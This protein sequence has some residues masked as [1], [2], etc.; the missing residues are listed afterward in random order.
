MARFDTF[1]R[2]LVGAC[3]VIWLAVIGVSVAAT[4][5]LIDLGSGRA[6]DPA[7]SSQTPWVLYAIIGI[8]AAII[9]ASIPLLLRARR[10]AQAAPPEPPRRT[11]P[12]ARAR[13]EVPTEKLPVFGAVA[14]PVGRQRP[15]GPVRRFNP[16]GLRTEPLDRVL[17]RTA[18]SLAAAMGLAALAVMTAA[19]FLAVKD[20]GTAWLALSIAALI[21]V[22]MP[23][24]PWWQLRELRGRFAGF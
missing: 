19:Y 22:A 15:S 1:D 8:S 12:P 21:T 6:S 23:V 17:L 2:L 24:I 14:A 7:P 5:A 20:D 4:V 3:A 9:L 16:G 13:T 18:G 10:A 11:P